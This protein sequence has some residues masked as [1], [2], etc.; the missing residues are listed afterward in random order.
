MIKPAPITPAPGFIVVRAVDA[1]AP[2]L[3]RARSIAAL[4]PRPAYATNLLLES[5]VWVLVHNPA[6][7]I[8]QMIA[9]AEA[10]T[11]FPQR[12]LSPGETLSDRD[13]DLQPLRKP[14]P[15]EARSAPTHGGCAR[16]PGTDAANADHIVE[17]RPGNGP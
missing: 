14:A 7:E 8:M 6:A 15:T 17:P 10:A 16:T 5:G 12:C 3:I 2:R 13:D 11:A 1:D 4:A 9:A